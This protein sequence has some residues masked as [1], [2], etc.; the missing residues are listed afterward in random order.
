MELWAERE[1]FFKGKY[2][3]FSLS[4]TVQERNRNYKCCV[5]N[6]NFING[7]NLCVR[8][9]IVE[10]YIRIILKKQKITCSRVTKYAV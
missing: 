1:K 10:F 9:K 7:L 8:L 3:S 5:N 2:V 6:K 4:G